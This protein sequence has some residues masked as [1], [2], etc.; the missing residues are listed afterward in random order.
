MTRAELIEEIASDIESL[1]LFRQIAV[2]YKNSRLGM[3]AD[4]AVALLKSN[5]SK[6]TRDYR[7]KFGDQFKVKI[8]EHYL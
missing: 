8:L 3:L 5:I 6:S 1:H 7:T 4:E 2:K